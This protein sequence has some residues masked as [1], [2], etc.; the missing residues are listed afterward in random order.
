[1]ANQTILLDYW[2]SMFGMRARVA[3]RE[4]GV[5]FEYREEDLTNKSPLL[6]QSNP[7]H[8]K[9][10]V[11]I[12]NGKPVCESLNV[13]Q[14]VDEAWSDKNPFFPSDPYGRAHARFWADFVDKKFSDAQ[15][16]I[17]GKKGEEQ[18][19]GKKEFIEAV[20]TLESELGDKPYF[21]GDSFGYVD[22]SLITFYS[23]FQA[24]E[25]LGNFS[26]EAESPKLIAWCKR[27]MEKESVSKSL[28]DSEKIVAYAAQF[29]KNN[30]GSE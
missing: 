9:I 21:G 13:V 30:L 29:R 11:L 6:L 28:P 2:P 22:I 10:P 27:C 1:M 14:Y 7:I 15:F 26:I 5:E 16:K 3:L 4:K 19:A 12:H 17:W 20:K 23:W 8:K 25:K 24:Y 18:E